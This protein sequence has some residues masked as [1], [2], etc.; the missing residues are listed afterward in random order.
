MNVLAFLV[1]S[2][3]LMCISSELETIVIY[4]LC[5]CNG[6]CWTFLIDLGFMDLWTL[7][8]F[9]WIL[10]YSKCIN[11]D[12]FD[13]EL[14]TEICKTM[15]RLKE[16]S[17]ASLFYQTREQKVRIILI[18]VPFQPNKVQYN[19]IIFLLHRLI[20]LKMKSMKLKQLPLWI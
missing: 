5:W 20:H 17:I 7:V 19:R 18:Q 6:V 12:L 15:K 14:W 9:V 10:N 4:F 11:F 13:V 1:L 3:T 2:S 16:I 8:F